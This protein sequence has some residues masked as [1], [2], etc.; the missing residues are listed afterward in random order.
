MSNLTI[1][2]SPC[3]FCPYRR[4][5]PSGVW[6]REEYAKLV[7]YDRE[8]GEQPPAAFHCH[9]ATGCLCSGWAQVHGEELLGLR[10]ARSITGSALP[11]PA[12]TVPLFESGAAAARHG[13]N[14]ITRPQHRARAAMRKLAKNHKRRSNYHDPRRD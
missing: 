1:R 4:D 14:D 7:E 3:A 9:E 2:R 8:T 5:V 10:L 12:P 11:I 13:L 6:H